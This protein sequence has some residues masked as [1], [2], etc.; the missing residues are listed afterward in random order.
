VIEAGLGGRLDA[1]NVLPS[2]VTALTSVGLEHTQWLGETTEEIAGEKLAVLRDHTALIAGPV[3]AGVDAL[4]RRTAAERHA[5]FVPVR[6]L[7]PG[8]ELASPAPYQRRNFAVALACVDVLLGSLDAERVRRVAAEIELRGR[9]EV[10]EEE[11][12]LILDAA[13]NPDGARAVVEALAEIA[14]GREVVACLAVLD[15]KD[16]AGIVD[17]LAPAVSAVVATEIPA[18]R[19]E[20]VGRPGARSLPASQL[21]TAAEEAGIVRAEAVAEAGAA[22][23]RA[24]AL[25]AE[26]EGVA[27]VCGS[28]YLLAYA[29]GGRPETTR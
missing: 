26:R 11:P 12:D 27:L 8:V 2:K 21:A 17:A 9:M 7:A 18:E 16:G 15:D 5:R 29:A 1:T 10:I 23:D 25:A 28:H 14:R 19:L 4:A 24:R 13:H 22:I 3:D 20:N 6:D